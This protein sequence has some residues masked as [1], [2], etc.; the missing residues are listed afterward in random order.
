M[1]FGLVDQVHPFEVFILLTFRKR[2]PK[3]PVI[4]GFDPNTNSFHKT[5]SLNQKRDSA[6]SHSLPNGKLIIGD[7]LPTSLRK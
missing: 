7:D 6:T 3:L 5:G 4:L 2:M 1:I